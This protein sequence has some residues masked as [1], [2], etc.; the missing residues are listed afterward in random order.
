MTSSCR[1][2]A[3]AYPAKLQADLE[4]F[5]GQNFAS[6][7]IYKRYFNVKP[8]RTKHKLYQNIY[9]NDILQHHNTLFYYHVWIIQFRI[10]VNVQTL[11][12]TAA[13]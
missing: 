3:E 12:K 13:T 10:L 8:S 9:V 5:C 4:S 1:L 11:G 2:V 6:E 7:Y